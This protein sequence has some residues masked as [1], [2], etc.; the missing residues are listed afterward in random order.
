MTHG[1]LL[2]RSFPNILRVTC[3]YPV[4]KQSSGLAMAIK[5]VSMP[6]VMTTEDPHMQELF[7]KY[8]LQDA[9]AGI[10]TSWTPNHT[11]EQWPTNSLKFVPKALVSVW[12][13]C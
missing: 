9:L 6:D 7:H 2:S 4:F 10:L 13:S 11:V 8:R 12:L 3:T 5:E 1:K